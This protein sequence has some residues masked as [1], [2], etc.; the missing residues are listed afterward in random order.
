MKIWLD[1]I[2]DSPDSTWMVARTYDDCIVRLMFNDVQIISLDHDLGEGKSGYDVA[3]TIERWVMLAQ[4]T[5]P[6][7]LIHTANPVGRARIQQVIDS[8]E[9]YTCRSKLS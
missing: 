5:A 9:R 7:I 2:R 8:I 1:D 4:Y 3:C 6:T